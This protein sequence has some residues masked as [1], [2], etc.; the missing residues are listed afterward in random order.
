MSRRVWHRAEAAASRTV[1]RVTHVC[2]GEVAA[3]RAC[4]RPALGR[5]SQPGQPHRARAGTR[6]TNRTQFRVSSPWRIS[7]VEHHLSEGHA[8]IFAFWCSA[9]GMGWRHGRMDGGRGRGARAGGPDR[10]SR[11]VR[12][13]RCAA[14]AAPPRRVPDPAGG[15][16][17]RLRSSGLPRPRTNKRP[18]AALTRLWRCPRARAPRRAGRRR[19]RGAG[20]PGRPTPSERRPRRY[21]QCV[22]AAGRAAAET[23]PDGSKRTEYRN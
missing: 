1:R 23:G 14:P 5:G 12:I 21:A 8:S 10:G 15:A 7:T 6:V 2:F 13:V 20:A 16:L 4:S 17:S 3:E 11:H 19:G 9:L 22:V 18:P